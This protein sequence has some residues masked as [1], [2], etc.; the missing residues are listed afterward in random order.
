MIVSHEGLETAIALAKRLHERYAAEIQEFDIRDDSATIR[1]TIPVSAIGSPRRPP[2]LTLAER[3][4]LG[5]L[6]S[7]RPELR[8]R[9]PRT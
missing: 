3:R 9:T 4:S 1:L 8:P 2:A 5:N 7:D 6:R